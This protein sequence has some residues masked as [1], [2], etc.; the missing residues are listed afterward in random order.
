MNKNWNRAYKTHLNARIYVL[1][2]ETKALEQ[3]NID[4]VES[5]RFKRMKY[6]SDY[7][8]EPLRKHLTSK[9][10][11]DSH[12]KAKAI[13]LLNSFTQSDL[14]NL[15]RIKTYTKAYELYCSPLVILFDQKP[16]RKATADGKIH[17][18]YWKSAFKIFQDPQFMNKLREFKLESISQSKFEEI[19][20][21]IRDEKF[22]EDN[23]ERTNK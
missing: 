12:I 20:R 13:A 3:D 7:E 21:F 8:I 14:S 19:E 4:I 23:A 2:D 11:P 15:R 5:I 22:H 17:V 16:A 1:S 10:T 6:C 18:S 9:D